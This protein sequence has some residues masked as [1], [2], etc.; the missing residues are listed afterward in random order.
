VE[1]HA[2]SA[3]TG[4]GVRSLLYAI[5]AAVEQ[6]VRAAP[7]REGFVLHRPV[8]AGFTVAREGEAWVVGGKAAERAIAFADLTVPEAA[9]L[10]AARLTRLGVDDA[11]VAAG[12]VAGDEVRIGDVAF[13]FRPEGGGVAEEEPA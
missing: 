11:L 5:V 2:V 10:A 9:D 4:A 1:I 12:A 3:V 8:Q 7:D 6:A 13:E